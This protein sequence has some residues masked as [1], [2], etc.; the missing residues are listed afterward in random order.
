MGHQNMGTSAVLTDDLLKTPLWDLHKNLGGKMT[1]FAG[2]DMPI[3][4]EM[5]VL[6][7]HLHCRDAAGLFDVS[8]MGQ[9][10]LHD[11][12]QDPARALEEITCGNL[13][14]LK[15]GA[16]RYTLFLNQNGGIID[17]LMVTRIDGHTLFLVV[18]A[19]RKEI[20]LAYLESLQNRHADLSITPLR[21]RALVALQGPKAEEALAHFFAN[22]TSLSFMQMTTE[23]F[24]GQEIYINRCGYTGDDGFEISLPA[25]IAESFCEKLLE[26]DEVA[27]IGLGARDSLRLE[28]GL[29]LYGQDIDEKTNPVMANLKWAVAKK[30]RENQNFPGAEQIMTDFEKGSEMT[31]I[32]LKPEGRGAI[33]H[34]TALYNKEGAEIGYVT[35]GCF[36][37]TLDAPVAMGYVQSEYA[38][39][40]T[41]IIAQQRKKEITCEV[42]DMPFRNAGY[43]K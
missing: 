1:G 16:M 18:N 29:C 8:H 26:M 39:T 37:P 42:A 23:N 33:R 32:G 14:G 31:R 9:V 2:Y 35:S 19:A 24:E 28:A 17:D 27:P 12:K 22:V 25:T 40:G 15:D 5:G 6:K 7:E 38:K 43:K 36:A 3:Q 10:I 30:R 11:P 34:G 13:T 41:E 21:D 4:Y 20:D